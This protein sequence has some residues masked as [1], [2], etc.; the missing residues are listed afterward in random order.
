MEEKKK[1]KKGLD[2][3]LELVV[4]ILL[5]VTA[6]LTAW[7]S[8]IGALH[9][10]NQATNYT[11][12]NNLAS[13][14]NSEYNAGVQS[15]TQ[16]MLLYN[17]VTSMEIDLLFAEL[18]GEEDEIARLTWKI[19][20]LVKNNMSE[21]FYDA[22]EWARAQV[23]VAGETVSP[24]EKEGFADSYFITANELLEE[25]EEIL[26]QGQQDNQNGDSFGLVSV[27]YSVVLFLLG[28]V[29]TFK[30][31]KNR[32]AVIGIA[33][34]AFIVATIYMFTLPM[35]TGFSLGSFFGASGAS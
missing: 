1:K 31:Q 25:S 28:I 27:I 35:P 5:G 14:G 9:G 11:R 6:V 10:G 16:D 30:G 21:E 15:M 19:E 24:F 34:V 7:A 32:I 23:E 13:E 20:E 26:T 8:W 29:G 22:Y 18:N 33:G 2:E 4:V 17:E 12:S 3:I